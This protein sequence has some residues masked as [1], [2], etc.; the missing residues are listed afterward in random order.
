MQ[1]SSR[2]VFC[3]YV[4]CRLAFGMYVC[5]SGRGPVNVCFCRVQEGSGNENVCFCKILY[6]VVMLICFYVKCSM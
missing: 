6:S 1:D 2:H 5:V 3:V 4:E